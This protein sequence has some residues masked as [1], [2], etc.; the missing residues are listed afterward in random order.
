M[1]YALHV[2]AEYY[3]HITYLEGKKKPKKLLRKKFKIYHNVFP[4]HPNQQ[5]YLGW[6]ATRKD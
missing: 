1:S 5:L 4:T 3:V 2:Y 6:D